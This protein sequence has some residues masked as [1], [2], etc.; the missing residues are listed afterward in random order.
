MKRKEKNRPLG[1]VGGDARSDWPRIKI[2]YIYDENK[3]VQ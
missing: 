3:D 1:S 2:V